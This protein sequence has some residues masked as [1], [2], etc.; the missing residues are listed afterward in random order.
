[1]S[2]FIVIYNVE[3]KCVPQEFKHAKKSS[4]YIKIINNKRC[5]STN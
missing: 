5:C 2:F 1:M 3:Y 4:C